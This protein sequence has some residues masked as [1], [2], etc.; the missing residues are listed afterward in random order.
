[1]LKVLEITRKNNLKPNREKCEF[2]VNEPTFLGDVLSSEGLKPDRNKVRAIS[3][4]EKPT[5]KR[6]VQR[7]SR[8]TT[9]LEKWIPD[10]CT[11]TD[12]LHQLLIEKSEWQWGLEL[13]KAW[14]DLKTS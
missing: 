12:P 3:T 9:Y 11:L 8:M 14:K 10:L 1:M 7:F 6:G 4:M 13:E 5:N 2:G